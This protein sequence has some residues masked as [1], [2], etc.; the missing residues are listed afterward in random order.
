MEYMKE[1]EKL[2]P[3]LNTWAHTAVSKVESRPNR[4]ASARQLQKE[5]GELMKKYKKLGDQEKINAVLKELGDPNVRAEQLRQEEIFNPATYLKYIMFSALL[6]ILGAFVTAYPLL[7]LL[8]LSDFVTLNIE[9]FSIFED[10]K[11]IISAL[12]SG[13]VML[14]IGLWSI[15]VAKRYS[16]NRA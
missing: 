2:P 12:T 10:T 11:Q 9:A 13:L 4:Q 14:V 1:F 15:R 7:I 6:I 3:K 8:T 5:I 16:E